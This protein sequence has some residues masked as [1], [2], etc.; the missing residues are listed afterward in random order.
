MGFAACCGYLLLDG[1]VSCDVGLFRQKGNGNIGISQNLGYPGGVGWGGGVRWVLT[2]RRARLAS[3]DPH[4]GYVYQISKGGG[5]F[6]IFA[7]F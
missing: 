2:H 4:Q 7:L 3:Q 5:R 1:I 6:E